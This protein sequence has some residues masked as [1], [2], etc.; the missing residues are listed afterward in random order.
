MNYKIRLVEEED[1][2]F[3]VGLRNNSK[4]NR[5]LSSTSARVE[6]QVKWIK[7]YK[8]KEKK[9]EEF[10]FIV[11]ENG[12]RRGLYRI[13]KIN[14]VS[15]IIGSWLFDSCENKVLPILTDL[16][17]ADIGYYE[18]NKPILLL[19]VR[20]DNRKVIQ[21]HALKHPLFGSLSL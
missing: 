16:L 3:I 2:D 11:F 12:L 14:C 13:Y 10:Y 17:M 8:L 1:A 15:F 6:D 20:K 19:D 4:L 21:Y 18:L 9:K 5:H 7:D